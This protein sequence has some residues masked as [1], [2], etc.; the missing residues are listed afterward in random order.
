METPDDTLG[1]NPVGHSVDKQG[2]DGGHAYEWPPRH[3]I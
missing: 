2:W 1:I 3:L